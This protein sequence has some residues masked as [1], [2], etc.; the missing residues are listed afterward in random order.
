M[1]LLPEI[2][3]R[4]NR[5]EP[6]RS[7]GH[8]VE[9]T[10]MRPDD[11]ATGVVR[12][13]RSVLGSG[14]VGVIVPD[15][16]RDEVTEALDDEGLGWASELQPGAAPIVVLD[17]E[18]AKGLEFDN[19]VVVEPAQIAAESPQGLRA[20]FVAL[21]RPTRRLGLVHALSLPKVLGLES[22]LPDDEPP[23]VSSS[24]RS[25]PPEPVLAEPGGSNG[26][27]P[28]A[29]GRPGYTSLAGGRNVHDVHEVEEV[30]EVDDVDDVDEL[31]EDDRDGD[32]RDDLHAFGEG[33]GPIRAPVHREPTEPAELV[34]LVHRSPER[35]AA[36][37][38]A[39][40]PRTPAPAPSP[41]AP[42]PASPVRAGLTAHG[43][44]IANGI[45]LRVD[46]FGALDR[47]MAQAV[48]AKLVE[49]LSRYAMPALIPLVV[50][51]MRE[52]VELEAASSSPP[53]TLGPPPP[54][55]GLPTAPEDPP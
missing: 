38:P 33:G 9:V 14:L 5:P 1:R 30:E 17:A 20:L 48:A 3:P 34:Q 37:P 25:W 13:V 32:R 23:E 46:P 54:R 49:T 39:T 12:A 31:E 40:R 26:V 18:E 19:V 4:L 6:L 21:T 7:S 11:L 50:E 51:K 24:A 10:A 8:P 29:G 36:Q 55:P 41:A 52:I 2:A 28:G 47:E 16:E 53:S 22:P 43:A 44:P 15:R 42:A 35:P 45:D 27:G